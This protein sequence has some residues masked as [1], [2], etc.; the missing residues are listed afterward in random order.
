M[1]RALADFAGALLRAST[2]RL[3]LR[4]LGRQPRRSALVIA[5]VAIGL[6][7]LVF[8]MALQFGMV[9]QMAETAIRTEIGDLQVHARDWRES[10]PLEQRLAQAPALG[11]LRTQPL[12]RGVAP[13]LRGEGLALS[14]RASVGVRVLGIDAAREPA[15]TTLARL[16][17]SGAWFGVG[18][19]RVVIGEGL[20]RRLRIGLGD[21][22][23]L[24]VQDARG[25]LTGE[26]F[27]VG[28]LLRPPSRGLDESV[29]L[30][31]LGEAQRL[32]GVPG[33][34]SELAL[35][36]HKAEALDAAKQAAATALGATARVETWRELQPLLVAM[37]AMFDQVGWV[38]YAAIFVAMAF[39]IA[40]ALLM[41][42]FERTR[43]IGVLMAI[44]MPPARMVAIVVAE[45]LVTV[46]LGVACGFAL[47]FG[48]VWLVRDGIDLSA[49]SEGL[50]SFGV[51]TRLVPIVR[52]G[53]VWSPLWVATLTAL[54]ASLW[55]ALRAVRTRPAE[56][57]RRI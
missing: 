20:A 44:G 21:K 13:R 29:V 24:S 35:S 15:V 49:W 37:I 43:E 4:G 8:A 11:A 23:V 22:L 53:D 33:E 42:V 46:A 9:F 31:R 54:L 16:V 57:L 36:V 47:G 28:G 51:P 17:A 32:F 2:W 5:A 56:A 10:A 12:L 7:G 26:A 3:A 18:E 39:G 34:I 52:S 30:L 14:P 25:D 41:S 6:S 55:P 1:R 40:N 48:A 38:V 45:A 50:R 27:R 19:R